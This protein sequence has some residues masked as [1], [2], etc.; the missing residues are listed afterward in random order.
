MPRNVSG[1][2]AS[3]AT[4]VDTGPPRRPVRHLVGRRFSCCGRLV[5]RHANDRL[6]AAS[7]MWRASKHFTG[8][9]ADDRMPPATRG[10][11]EGNEHKATPMQLRVRQKQLPGHA[12]A[13]GLADNATSKIQNI[14]IERPG[15]PTA[16]LSPPR[17][18][19][20]TFQHSQK[21]GRRNGTVH[22]NNHVQVVRLTPSKGRGAINW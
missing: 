14:Q 7:E 19:L 10:R 4:G 17:L 5:Y 9:E 15:L 16:E 12:I 13:A 8:G 3:R 1:I 20:K 21:H 2:K 6:D 11:G 18:A 22:A